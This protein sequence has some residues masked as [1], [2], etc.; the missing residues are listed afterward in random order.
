M[1]NIA[2]YWLYSAC[3]FYASVE[4]YDVVV[5]DDVVVGVVRMMVVLNSHAAIKEAFLTS[6]DEFSDRSG[7]TPFVMDLQCG[8]YYTNFS[9]HIGDNNLH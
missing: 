4:Y 9:H 3:L 1:Q 8:M 2:F 7:D 6:G 5:F